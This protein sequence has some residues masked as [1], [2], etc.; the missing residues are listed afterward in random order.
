MHISRSGDQSVS[1]V[2]HAVRARMSISHTI[3]QPLSP[4]AKQVCVWHV[5]VCMHSHHG[6]GAVIVVSRKTGFVNFS[7]SQESGG[8]VSAPG[9]AARIERGYLKRTAGSTACVNNQVDSRGTGTPIQQLNVRLQ[10][11]ET[12]MTILAQER[13]RL[14]QQVQSM[15]NTPRQ[16]VQ[17]GVVDTRVIGKPDQFDGDPMKYADWSFKLRSYLGAVDQRYQDELTKTEAS[18]TP[19]LNANLGSEESALST[20]MYYILVMTTAGAALDKCHNAG[21]S[22]GFEAWDS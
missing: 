5:P 17:T 9:N 15:S 1:L 21:V 19:R 8:A 6:S 4:N 16:R 11:Q 7:V 2:E 18:S 13:E 22:E 12:P 20:Q 10:Q 3:L 14:E